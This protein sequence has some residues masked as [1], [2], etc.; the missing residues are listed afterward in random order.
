MAADK[1][2]ESYHLSFDLPVVTVRPFN[3]YG[4]R[5]SARAVIPTVVS[6]IAA[7]ERQISLGSLEPT[8][9]FNFVADTAEAF[10]SVVRADA[11]DVVGRVVQRRVGP[12]DLDRRHRRPHRRRHGRRGGGRAR[13]GAGPPG[14]LRGA[15]ARLRQQ[16]PA[17]RDVVEARPHPRGGPARHRRRGSPTPPTS[18]ATA[19]TGTPSDDRDRR[20]ATVHNRRAR[21]GSE[22]RQR[23][24]RPHRAV[25]RSGDPRGREGRPAA[26]LHHPDP[27]A[28]GADRRRALDPRDRAAAARGVGVHQGDHRHRS[29]RPAHPG[30]RRRRVAVGHRG[31]LRQRGVPARDHRPGPHH[32]GP[33]ARALPAHERR[34]PHRPRLRR[35]APLARRQRC[36]PDRGHLRPRAPRRLRGARDRRAPHH[37]ASPRSRG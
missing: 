23:G 10:V 26:P 19:P 5:Q 17:R 36:A 30:L 27:Q 28:A 33:A 21:Y 4:P 22:R 20:A 34:H 31:R 9:D 11:A 12:R 37:R 24:H 2:A 13:P 6:Q 3:T 18:P 32:R 16:R 7:G 14:R 35:P 25:P 15:A 29:P 1:L 8:R